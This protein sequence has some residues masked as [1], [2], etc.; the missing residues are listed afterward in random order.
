MVNSHSGS[1]RPVHQRL[2][3]VPGSDLR[4]QIL[5]SRS[6]FVR[7]AA[8]EAKVQR[9]ANEN[10]MLLEQLRLLDK[11]VALGNQAGN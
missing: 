3:A 4:E 6:R 7:I 9:L 1:A 2:G 5:R 10:K 11:V 8:T